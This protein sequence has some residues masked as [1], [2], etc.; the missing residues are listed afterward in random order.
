MWATWWRHCPPYDM[1]S[2][3]L[4]LLSALL[5]QVKPDCSNV[6]DVEDRTGLCKS[7]RELPEHLLD[8]EDVLD[9]SEY[10][11]TYQEDF[12][13]KYG[14]WI[15]ISII[16]FEVLTVICSYYYD[17]LVRWWIIDARF[18][19][20]HA[21]RK[22]TLRSDHFLSTSVKPSHYFKVFTSQNATIFNKSIS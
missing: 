9:L 17:L 19:W 14:K 1:T 3:F 4:S 6:P 11:K 22:F 21:L 13:E 18:N 8:C 15:Q 16:M 2:L 5:L 12:V 7:C 10:N 20:A